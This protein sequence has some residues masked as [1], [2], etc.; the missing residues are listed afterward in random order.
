MGD[1]NYLHPFSPEI[2]REIC[3]KLIFN[4][5]QR[6]R[7]VYTPVASGEYGLEKQPVKSKRDKL[8]ILYWNNCLKTEI[9]G[10]LK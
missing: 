1:T 2:L 4:I 6:K 9:T 3:D 5:N 10:R 7:Q 8:F